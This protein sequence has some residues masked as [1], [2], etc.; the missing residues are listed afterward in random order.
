MVAVL[1][2]LRDWYWEYGQRRRD[3]RVSAAS[4]LAPLQSDHEQASWLNNL[5]S[6][7]HGTA[8]CWGP[9]VAGKSSCLSR[10]LDNAGDGGSAL[11]WDPSEPVRLSAPWD[12]QANAWRLNP[13]KHDRGP[14]TPGCAV[15]FHLAKQVENPKFPVQLV[16]AS[17]VQMLEALAVGYL[18]ERESAQVTLLENDKLSARIHELQTSGPID[19]EAFNLL[20]AAREVAGRLG[21]AGWR[22]YSTLDVTSDPWNRLLQRAIELEKA[23]ALVKEL[24]F[25]DDQ[26]AWEQ[27]L[28]WVNQA[29]EW[30]KRGISQL[31]ATYRVAIQL[32]AAPGEPSEVRFR[33]EA[34]TWLVGTDSGD[35]FW[36]NANDARDRIASIWEMRIPIN[37]DRLTRNHS[38]LADVLRSHDLLDLPG[39][40]GAK[41]PLHPGETDRMLRHGKALAAIT[42]LAQAEALDRYLHFARAGQMECPAH[43][44]EPVL[45]IRRKKRS[46]TGAPPSA[47]APLNLV[48][49]Y[50]TATLLEGARDGVAADGAFNLLS[51]HL[52][53]MIRSL[54]DERREL[55][56]LS[57]PQDR[58]DHVAID[59]NAIG[60]IT[61][62]VRT[63]GGLMAH[64]GLEK[65][66][67]A[68]LRSEAGDGGLTSIL[69]ALKTQHDRPSG[70]AQLVQD[71]T[72][73]L[74]M[75]IKS[76]AEI[77]QP[78][79]NPQLTSRVAA[80]DRWR[81]RIETMLAAAANGQPGANQLVEVDPA[82]AM[83]AAL[84]RILDVDPEK[85]DPVPYEAAHNPLNDYVEAQLANMRQ[86]W[87]SIT[88]VDV[89]AVAL[90]DRGELIECLG[91]LQESLREPGSPMQGWIRTYLG[92]VV[93]DNEQRRVRRFLATWMSDVML[94]GPA[95]ADS[96]RPHRS[97]DEVPRLL[98]E[99]SEADLPTRGLMR[100][101]PSPYYDAVI[102]PFLDHLAHYCAPS[103][104]AQILSLAQK[105]PEVF[106]ATL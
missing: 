42:G 100:F 37:E 90:V 88:P 19:R 47:M 59:Q 58:L 30:Q 40:V 89:S 9:S 77:T 106:P 105:Y 73:R 54:G 25:A 24:F 98:H 50:C 97:L 79:R 70:L 86:Q 83:A 32:L 63:H 71:E 57:C 34:G 49:T 12:G 8:V 78:R 93:G 5:A 84:L 56:F 21:R 3:P 75:K 22:Q 4:W 35:I 1:A 48:T 33:Q 7:K 39:Y 20:W 10:Y 101:R 28:R 44:I 62:R 91:H 51:R 41:K 64:R 94:H 80:L 103:G 45:H 66:I 95:A 85:L 52:G 26:A 92:H 61:Q 87:T 60:R 27:A 23:Q 43:W 16:L 14:L 55:W 6:L 74:Q 82:H 69:R 46:E 72:T 2:E 18:V 99:Y 17:P 65:R 76:L 96:V 81:Q 38:E 11:Q 13:I 36:Q 67:D 53:E 15:R 31:S 29:M 68:M 104:E 102:C